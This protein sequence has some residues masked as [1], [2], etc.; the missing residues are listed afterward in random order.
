MLTRIVAVPVLALLI[1]VAAQAGAAA[2]KEPFEYGYFY[3]TFGQDPNIALLAGGTAE[4]F[5]ADNPEDPFNGSPATTSATVKESKDGSVSV[6]ANANGQP[7]HLYYVEVE[8]APV[9]IE[10]VCA[11]IETGADAPEPFA[12]GTANLRVRDEYLFDGGPPLSIFNSVNGTV[13]GTDGT[14]YHVRASADI[15]FENGVPVGSPPDWVS[16]SLK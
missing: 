4:E 14:R 11:D 13:F 12:S 9:W 3:G 15:P 1:G 7:V 16:F 2:A 5:C 8:G 10:Q 6:K